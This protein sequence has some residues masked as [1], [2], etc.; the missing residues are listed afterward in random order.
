MYDWLTDDVQ[1][2]HPSEYKEIYKPLLYCGIIS[3][4][5]RSMECAGL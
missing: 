5:E 3:L 4:N 2:F 1:G